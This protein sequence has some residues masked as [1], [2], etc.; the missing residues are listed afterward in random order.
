[1]CWPRI[2]VLNPRAL[3]RYPATTNSSR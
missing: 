1:L 2:N 3:G